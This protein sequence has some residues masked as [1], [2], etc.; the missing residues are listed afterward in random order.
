MAE[1]K[2]AIEIA[3]ERAAVLGGGDDHETRRQARAKGKALARRYLDADLDG[4]GIIAG[5]AG[6]GEGQEEHARQ[7]LART[8]LLA[9]EEG[10][11]RA[12]AGLKTISPEGQAAQAWQDLASAEDA[13]LDSLATVEQEL[14]G[15]MLA[16]LVQAGIGGSAVRPNPMAHAEYGQRTQSALA[17]TEDQVALA[18]AKLR[19]ALRAEQD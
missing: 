5:L 10:N 13:R 17:A 8:L 3:M 4:Q 16:R 11:A 12:L 14:A 9:L 19:A 7:G 18:T 6:L 2:S 15:E 1:I